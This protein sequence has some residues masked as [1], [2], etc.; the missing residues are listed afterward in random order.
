MMVQDGNFK[1]PQRSSHGYLSC[2]CNVLIMLLPLEK[3]MRLCHHF[4]GEIL[5]KIFFLSNNSG[6]MGQSIK[7]G[8][9]CVL[10]LL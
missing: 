3:L 2:V 8:L 1:A 4:E 10:L 6:S 5:G 7:S 9:L